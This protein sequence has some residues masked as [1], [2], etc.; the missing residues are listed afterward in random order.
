MML[1]N[2]CLKPSHIH[3]VLEAEALKRGLPITWTYKDVHNK[4]KLTEEEKT[5]DA[6]NLGEF[7]LERKLQHG[8]AYA[9]T[10]DEDGCLNKAFFEMEG[11]KEI[12]ARGSKTNILLCDTTVSPEWGGV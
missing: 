6:T 10:T 12:W 11:A 9:T 2:G 7:L 5:F 4:F 1:K 8:V 3:R